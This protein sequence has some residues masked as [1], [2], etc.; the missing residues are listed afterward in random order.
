MS[1]LDRSE[2]F[3]FRLTPEERMM[4][5][6]VAELDGLSPSDTLRQLVRRA[7]AESRLQ[8]P[9]NGEPALRFPAPPLKPQ[10]KIK[11]SPKAPKKK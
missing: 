9:N 1:P 5:D 11:R 6:T 10:P 2:K 4:L 7:F 8:R 3:Q